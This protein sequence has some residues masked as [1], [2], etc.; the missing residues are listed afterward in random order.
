M[1]PQNILISA[2]LVVLSIVGSKLSARVGA[3]TLLIFLGV[4]IVTTWLLKT[5][6]FQN[7]PGAK[8]PHFKDTARLLGIV[9]LTFILFSGGLETKRKH[10]I[11]IWRSG[12]LLSTLGVFFSAFLVGGIL[13][14][15]QSSYDIVI[16]ALVGIILA[17]T[18]AAAVFS[19]LRSRRLYLKANLGPLVEL[20]SGSNDAMVYSGM[21]MLLSSYKA[22]DFSIWAGIGYFFGEMVIGM[23]GGV[24]GG[25]L[26]LR[27]INHI[28][29]THEGLYTPLSMAG[30]F[31]IYTSVALL[32]G[33][34]YLAVYIAG[35]ILGNHNF[36]HRKSILKVYEGLGWLLQI[37]MFIA[38]GMLV[39]IKQLI[40][41]IP[42][43]LLLS[44]ALVFFARP[45]S[46]FLSLAF[47]S[48][49]KRQKFFV[50]WA[51]LR[52]AV[53]IV[54]ATYLYNESFHQNGL[55]DKIVDEV[56]HLIFFVVLFSIIVQGTTLYSFAKR[57]KLD[58]PQKEQ[59]NDKKQ[60]IRITENPKKLLVELL[61]PEGAIAV[62]QRIVDLDLPDSV[63]IAAVD[64]AS[65]FYSV[66]GATVLYANDRLLVLVE[67]KK[68]LKVLKQCLGIT[69]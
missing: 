53:P 15:V 31:C 21:M 50:A 22:A 27:L 25:Y 24:L 47:S 52:G 14:M 39:D 13:Y 65:K 48:F 30:V 12:A 3:P 33:S 57:W 63:F 8:T 61:L 4:G 6:D 66:R 45:L 68:V 49:T 54:F 55:T 17:S 2:V 64:R 7:Y 20:E 43:G 16:C 28:N 46:V 34:G 67:N 59:K 60:K 44:F 38:L 18:D 9:T 42:W 29:L 40:D 10:L 69:S 36:I 35:V 41:I 5:L 19:I 32:H 62:G 58:I 26:L 11:P 37:C 23:I 1:T 56:F 51:G